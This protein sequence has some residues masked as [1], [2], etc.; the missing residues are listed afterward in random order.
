M[1]MV[2]KHAYL[3]I[4]LFAAFMLCT[5]KIRLKG[6]VEGCALNNHENYIVDHRKSW[7]NHGIVF[8][9]FC[10]NPVIQRPA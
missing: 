7:K 5:V 2:Y 8:L 4:L 3:D 6:E 10:G 9:K 1:H